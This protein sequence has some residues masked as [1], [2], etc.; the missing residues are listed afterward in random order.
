MLVAIR[1]DPEMA[2]LTRAKLFFDRLYT[3]ELRRLSA[4][5]EKVLAA[6]RANRD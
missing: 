6:I 4:H 5:G 1:S 2:A 3:G